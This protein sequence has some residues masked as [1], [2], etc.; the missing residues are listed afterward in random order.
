MVS[1]ITCTIRESMLENIFNNFNRQLWDKKE[2]II[3]LN[4]DEM[5]R[6]LWEEKASHTENI[7]VY[8]LPKAKTLG[9]CLNF[10]I[11]QAKYDIIAKFDDDDYYSEYYLSEAMEVFLTT[12][13][14]LVGKGNS[15]MFYEEHEL[16][17]LR[18]IGSENKPGKSNLKGGTLT[19]RKS[20][21]PRIKFPS[22]KGSGT[23]SAF[24][25]ICKKQNIRIHTTSKYNY[26]YIR[27]ANSESHTYKRSNNA[28]LKRS[29]KVGKIKNY[30]PIVTKPFGNI[31]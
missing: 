23:D 5:N 29:T 6:V 25:N 20:L 31:N 13:A 3:I 14:E 22:I 4:N 9:E 21:Y 18:K 12:D 11:E 19:F 16:L 30:Y 27:R 17:A 10:G 1:V 8:Q 26:V 28:L 24:V 2:L 7:R 15:Y